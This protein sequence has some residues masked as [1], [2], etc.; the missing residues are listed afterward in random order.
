VREIVLF[1]VFSHPRPARLLGRDLQATP[2]NVIYVDLRKARTAR[3]CIQ[4]LLLFFLL[5]RKEVLSDNATPAK[6]LIL[7]DSFELV[8]LVSL[9][10]LAVDKAGHQPVDSKPGQRVRGEDAQGEMLPNLAEYGA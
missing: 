1:A 3:S 5:C 10:K 7:C 6:L 4:L 2:L 8:C 9:L